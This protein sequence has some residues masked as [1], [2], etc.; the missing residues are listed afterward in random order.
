[1]NSFWDEEEEK[2]V[3]NFNDQ[4]YLIFPLENLSILQDLRGKIFLAAKEI[5]KFDEKISENTFFNKTHE[6]LSVK[7]LNDFRVALIAKLVGEINLR[8]LLYRLGKKHINWVVGN[9]LA[10]QRSIGLSIQF[11]QDT[12][13]L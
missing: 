1:M 8:P 10:M 7:D 5:L 4:G 3:K 2:I 12:S 6:F 11:P 13:S 9:E